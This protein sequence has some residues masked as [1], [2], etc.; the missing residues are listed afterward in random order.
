MVTPRIAEEVSMI[1][2]TRLNQLPLVVNSDLI[3]HIEA[4][5]DTVIVL[6]NGQK[7]L[8]LETPDEV[9]GRVIN[10]RRALLERPQSIPH[11]T[12]PG[13]GP[14]LGTEATAG[15]VALP[16]NPATRSA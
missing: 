3:E 14:R 6:T 12:A 16:R 5:P 11:A 7:I 1:H 13:S 9:V 8:V 10:F 2:L 15:S 4:T